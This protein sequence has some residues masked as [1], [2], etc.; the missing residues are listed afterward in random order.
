M[1]CSMIII[2]LD[3]VA[4]S[5]WITMP[6]LEGRAALAGMIMMMGLT[7]VGSSVLCGPIPFFSSLVSSVKMESLFAFS[8][9]TVGAGAPDPGWHIYDGD[10]ELDRMGVLKPRRNKVASPWR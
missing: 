7:G 3:E 6:P 2:S 9:R 1:S 5:L 4:L 10:K 8:H